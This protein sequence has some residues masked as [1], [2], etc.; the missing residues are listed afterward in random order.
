MRRQ[1]TSIIL[2]ILLVHYRFH[3]SPLLVP[4][5]CKT[6][7]TY[8]FSDE[9][10]FFFF[11][12]CSSKSDTKDQRRVE[13]KRHI[14]QLLLFAIRFKFI[15]IIF[16][17]SGDGFFFN[18]SFECVLLFFVIN[19]R[20]AHREWAVEWVCVWG[21]FCETAASDW[22]FNV[23]CNTGVHQ[24]CFSIRIIELV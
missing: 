18:F 10:R 3:S 23:S 9:N 7:V 20:R 5:T 11:Y 14:V 13:K 6:C 15:L 22:C 16:H 1:E 4:W 12:F 8:I 19:F 2:L 21:F 24:F 17:F